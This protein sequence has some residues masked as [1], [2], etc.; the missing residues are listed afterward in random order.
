MREDKRV[1]DLYFII[2]SEFERKRPVSCQYFYRAITET[3]FENEQTHLPAVR[4]HC[5]L[6]N[7]SLQGH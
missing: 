7:E 1:M 2:F 5:G 6:Y 3:K 4:R